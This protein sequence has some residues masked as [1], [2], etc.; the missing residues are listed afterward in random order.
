MVLTIINQID[1]FIKIYTYALNVSRILLIVSVKTVYVYGSIIVRSIQYLVLPVKSG[2]YFPPS[3]IIFQI[4][5]ESRSP[6]SEQEFVL[7][8]GFSLKSSETENCETYGLG[9]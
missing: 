6:R 5:C 3:K 7:I 8:L 1:N 9:I 2:S 4:H